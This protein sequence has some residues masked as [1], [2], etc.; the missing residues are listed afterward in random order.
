MADLNPANKLPYHFSERPLADH[1]A[2][3]RRAEVRV[4]ER[5]RYASLLISRHGSTLFRYQA[6]PEAD[7]ALAH[8]FFGH[9][10]WRRYAHNMSEAEKQQ[11]LAFVKE[12]E[13]F[14]RRQRSLLLAD[15]NFAEAAEPARLNLSFRLLQ[16]CDALSLFVCLGPPERKKLPNI[17]RGS[18]DDRVNLSLHPAGET[19][20]VV[21]PYPFRASPL[22]LRVRGRKLPPG[23]FRDANG[24]EDA[25]RRAPEETLVFTVKGSG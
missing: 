6:D 2:L 11:I 20:A 12:R 25:W 21:E 22:Q 4:L 23:P 17:A 19:A 15:P 8:P 24:L 1:F 18:W 14:Q 9:E 10:T 7:P 16:V 5:S 13:E 3:W